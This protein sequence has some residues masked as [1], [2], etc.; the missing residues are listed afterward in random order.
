MPSQEL[1][2]N[3]PYVFVV[4]DDDVVR[5]NIVKNLV[6]M[7]CTVREFASGEALLRTLEN[8][9]ERPDVIV[10]DY[11]MDGMNGVDTVRAVRA[12]NSSVPAFI[13]T[14]YAG[15]LD[16]RLVEQLGNCEV[17]VK[18]VDLHSLRHIVQGAMALKHLQRAEPADGLRAED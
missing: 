6:R 7:K 15:G 14:A 8:P 18:T 1:A 16:M 10:L 9:Q 2:V 17:L 3:A 12:R 5:C 11:K 4:D 13:L